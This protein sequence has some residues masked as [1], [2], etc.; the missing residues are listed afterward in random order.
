MVNMIGSINKA[1][2]QLHPTETCQSFSH[3]TE[4][5]AANGETLDGRFPPETKVYEPVFFLPC[6]G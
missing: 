1:G 6:A 2:L 4:E 5:Q 3:S